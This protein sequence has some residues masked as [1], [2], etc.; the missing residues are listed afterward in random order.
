MGVGPTVDVRRALVMYPV[1]QVSK[2]M[3]DRNYAVP[4]KLEDDR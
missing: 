2:Q 1:P 4:V 3:I